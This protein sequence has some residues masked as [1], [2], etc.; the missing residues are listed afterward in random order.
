MLHSA[1]RLE[2]GSADI[3]DLRERLNEISRLIDGVS[4]AV[5]SQAAA[6]EVEAMPISPATCHVNEQV[7]R[8]LLWARR[9]RDQQFGFGLFADPAW[10]ILLE[11]YA[12]DLAQQRISVS[13]LRAR[14][15]VP[16]T[17]AMRWISKLEE[18]GWLVRQADPLDRRRYWLSLTSQ[19][20]ERLRG[21]FEAVWPSLFLL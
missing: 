4:S 18:D 1:P 14:A 12:A 7:V 2:L 15:G 8:R 19:A 10:D 16:K 3:A 20:S 5:S 9:L 11:V 13:D 17:T 21:Y 6:F